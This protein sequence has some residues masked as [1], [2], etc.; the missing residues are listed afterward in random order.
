MFK[1][2]FAVVLVLCMALM[3][4]SAFAD[5][6]NL[7]GGASLGIATDTIW[8]GMKLSSDDQTFTFQPSAYLK[9]QPYSK[10]NTLYFNVSGAYDEFVPTMTNMYLIE[11]DLG[12][13]KNIYK[14]FVGGIGYYNAKL[15]GINIIFGDNISEIYLTA[16]YNFEFK[17]FSVNPFYRF[18]RDISTKDL[19]SAAW[20]IHAIGVTVDWKD[21][22]F[23]SYFASYL[24]DIGNDTNAFL[25]GEGKLWGKVNI[26]PSVYI[27]P[28]VGF[29]QPLSDVAK[30]S[31]AAFNGSDDILYFGSVAVSIE[32]D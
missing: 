9:L 17:D 8:R 31:L 23:A 19:T 27:T 28:M 10:D 6:L 14:G 24:Q 26:F 5:N 13:K 21:L 22:I 11:A 1:K 7:S 2:L 29:S 30:V 3:G 18:S 15:N 25:D 12:F 16:G 4:T 20:N 32:F